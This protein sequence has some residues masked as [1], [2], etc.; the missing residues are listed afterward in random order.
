M[1][2]NE[3]TGSAS[4]VPDYSGFDGTR[5][6]SELQRFDVDALAPG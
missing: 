5:A 4:Q 3:S 6:V 1:A 2:T